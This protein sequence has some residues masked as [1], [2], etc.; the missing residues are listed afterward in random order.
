MDNEEYDSH[1]LDPVPE[2]PF[3]VEHIGE[4]FLI[5]CSI[6][7]RK[8][9]VQFSSILEACGFQVCKMG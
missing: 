9:N 4:A 8:S 2:D 5:Y 6:G 3:L 1:Y 7:M